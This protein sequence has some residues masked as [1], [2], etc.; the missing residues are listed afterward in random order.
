MDDRKHYLGAS[1]APAIVGLSRYRTPLDVWMEKTGKSEGPEETL[2][3]KV[4]TALEPVVISLFEE[5]TGDRVRNRQ[6]QIAHR[7]YPFIRATLDG[8]THYAVVEAKTTGSYEGWGEE[9]T[10]EVPVEY[11]VQTQVQMAVTGL[12]IAWIPVLIGRADFRI[13]K[14]QKDADLINKIIEREVRFWDLVQTRT[15]PEPKTL[16]DLSLAYPRDAGKTVIADEAVE[17]LVIELSRLQAKEKGIEE[18]RKE[19]EAGIK[20]FMKDAKIL[21]SQ[22]GRELCSWKTQR[23]SRF[24]GKRFKVEQLEL[25]KQYKKEAKKRVFRIKKGI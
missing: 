16:S 10:D 3:M 23:S 11:I 12:S 8:T 1:E 6:K 17:E 5:R 7:D 21:T 14:I 2:A 18:R 9:G 25:Y 19:L 15:M 24:D 22:D 13:Y 4:G 20:G